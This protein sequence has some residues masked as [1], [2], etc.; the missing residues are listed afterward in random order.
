MTI[1]AT[2]DASTRTS[3]RVD[4]VLDAA[5]V[6]LA[7]RGE[8]AVTIPELVRLTFI[9][10]P[11]IYQ[12][13][14]DRHAVLT[15][16]LERYLDALC[17]ELGRAWT[18]PAPPTWEERIDRLISYAVRF[19]EAHDPARTLMLGG[20]YCTVSPLQR[21][22]AREGLDRWV[23]QGLRIDLPRHT[24]VFGYAMGI[25]AATFRH[26]YLRHGR[27]TVQTGEHATRAV[28]AYVASF[29]GPSDR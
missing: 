14:P 28:V 17:T 7:R 8:S 25:A 10:S 27:V 15:A 12:L 6:I 2:L 3:M 11:T 29:L 19:L 20:P 16:L 22:A 26:G 21:L 23:M 5:D 1:A 4:A 9:E 18:H 13:F 24:D